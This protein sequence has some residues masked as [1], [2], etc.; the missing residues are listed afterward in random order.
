MGHLVTVAT[1][2][3][4]QWV[5]D[6]EGNTERII[7]SIH[8]AKEAGA[9]LRVGPELEITGYGESMPSLMLIRA[10]VLTSTRSVGSLHRA[11]YFPALVGDDPPHPPR[12]EL[13]RYPAGHWRA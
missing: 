4:N 3:L 5:L 1:C 13:P 7:K 8:L 2:S 6:W 12:Q 9:R 10:A 11:G